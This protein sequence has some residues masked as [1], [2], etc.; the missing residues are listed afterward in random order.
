MNSKPVVFVVV[1][2]AL[3]LAIGCG[4]GAG[5][6]ELSFASVAGGEKG[7]SGFVAVA[8]NIDGTTWGS[9]ALFANDDH[10]DPELAFVSGVPVAMY[11]NSS[12]NQLKTRFGND[13]YGTSWG[14]EQTIDPTGDAGDP[15]DL[16]DLYGKA[17]VAYYEGNLDELRFARVL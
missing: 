7:G 4:G 13:T 2:G 5:P 1:I 9:P 8:T 14:T 11:Y 16:I 10:D 17:G 15:H 6:L 12:A 3:L